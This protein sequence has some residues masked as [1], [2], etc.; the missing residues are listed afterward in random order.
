MRCVLVVRPDRTVGAR[1]DRWEG[2]ATSERVVNSEGR[3][4]SCMGMGMAHETRMRRE[5]VKKERRC[6]SR[7]RLN[8]ELIL[9]T[10][11]EESCLSDG[12]AG[13]RLFTLPVITFS[14]LE[15]YSVNICAD[16]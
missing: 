11:V 4:G 7:W 12:N 13:G 14:T 16:V 3:R 2:T 1:G 9:P 5:T 8:S 10:E 6:W 15:W